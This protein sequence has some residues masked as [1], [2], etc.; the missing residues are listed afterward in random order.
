MCQAYDSFIT[1]LLK[2]LLRMSGTQVIS[3]IAVMQDALTI[4]IYP[5]R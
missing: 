5:Y 1:V 3:K 4:F 2:Q